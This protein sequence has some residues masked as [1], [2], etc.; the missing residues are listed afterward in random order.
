MQN[1]TRYVSIQL[2]IG[3][4]QPFD[5]QTVNKN[6][7]GDCKALSNYMFALLKA[8]NIK[9]HYAIVFAG[10]DEQ[11]IDVTFPSNQFNHAILCIPAPKD[12]IWLECTSQTAP[13]GY[14]GS[15]TDNRNV[16][17]ITPEGGKIA[18]TTKYTGKNNIK[19]SISFIKIDDSGNASGKSEISYKNIFFDQVSSMIGLTFDEMRKSLKAKMEYSNIEFSEIQYSMEKKRFPQATE[20]IDFT[21]KNYASV[22]NQRLFLPLNFIKKEEITLKKSE[23]R[24]TD[25]TCPLFGIEKDSLVFEIPENYTPEYL[26]EKIKIETEFGSY[27]TDIKF[28]NNKLYYFRKTIFEKKK[29]KAEKYNDFIDFMIIINKKDNEDAVFIKNT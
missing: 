27:E 15:F 1:R 13:F 16:L 9:S 29:Y 22:S 19:S 21:L 26:P 18:R 14:I 23:N 20:K 10:T 6:G 7:Y 8:V 12:T 17:L 3:G 24:K 25:F 28:E 5:A 2:G 4:W 11:N